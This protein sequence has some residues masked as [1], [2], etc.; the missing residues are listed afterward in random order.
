MPSPPKLPHPPAMHSVARCCLRHTTAGGRRPQRLVHPTLGKH[1][2]SERVARAGRSNCEL[3][4]QT[5]NIDKDPY[6]MKNHLGSYAPPGCPAPVRGLLCRSHR[7]RIWVAGHV[8]YFAGCAPIASFMGSCRMVPPYISTSRR[9]WQQ[10]FC[11]YECKLCLTLHNNEGNYLAHT[12]GKRHQVRP[13]C[14]PF[15]GHAPRWVGLC[16]TA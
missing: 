8:A 4:L 13:C 3:R 6:F 12:Q 10:L 14:M 2:E 9:R 5:I 15:R 7:A 11:R 16:V 1:D